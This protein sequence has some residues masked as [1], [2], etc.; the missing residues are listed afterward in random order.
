MSTTSEVHFALPTDR[1]VRAE[2]YDVN[3]RIVRTLLANVPFTAGEHAVT[4][5]G[6]EASGKRARAGMY[7]LYVRA[8][9]EVKTA[10]MLLVP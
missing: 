1:S 9:S 10:R 3:G 2:V 4:W 6:R 5:D 7:L 8:G